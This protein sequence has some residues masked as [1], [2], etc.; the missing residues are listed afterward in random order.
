[1][2]KIILNNQGLTMLEMMIASLI[3]LMIVGSLFGALINAMDY[4]EFSVVTSDL[5]SN[6]QL[7]MN[8]MIKELR[9]A[10][11]TAGSTPPDA[12]VLGTPPNNQGMLFYL[13]G[14]IDGDGTIVDVATGDT[15][16]LPNIVQYLY[17]PAKQQIVRTTMGTQKVLANNVTD[18][19]FD[20]WNTDVSLFRDEI[21]I[22][23]ELRKSTSK[24]RP[25]V[26][27][28]VSTVKLR[29]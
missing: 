28:A 8:L 19:H 12:G 24:G 10:T 11:R 5:Q 9:S 18:I 15:E 22:T 16:W 17:D 20:D 1:M 26:Y 4:W 21:K 2:K 14:D 13:P 23:L 7:A 6:G 29:N 27:S 25:V 3:F